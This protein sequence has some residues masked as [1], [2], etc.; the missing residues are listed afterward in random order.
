MSETCLIGLGAMGLGMARNILKAGVDLRGSDL[1]P[2][3]RARFTEAGGRAFD[4]AAEAAAGCDLLIL[5]VVNAAQARAALFDSGVV[6][7][8]GAGSTVMLCSTVAPDD[9]RALAADLEKAGHRLLDAPVSGGQ[10]GAEAGTLTLMTSGAEAAYDRAEPVLNAIAGTVHR[11]GDAPGLGA[12]Y[13]VVHQLAAGVHLVAAAEVMALG[14]RAGCDPEKLFEIV[15]T[16]AGQSWMFE[17]RVPRILAGETTPTSSV[18]IFVKDLGL[19][20]Q[21]GRDCATPLP[22]SAAAHQMMLAASAMGFGKL[23]DSCV[24]RAYEALTGYATKCTDGE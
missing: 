20:L 13:K 23:D 6:Q 5:M 4:S 1:S 10:V 12:T 3:A 2:Q 19:V 21:T 11:L 22:L 15:S 14:A 18:D 8:L 17:D 9:V 16:S 7:A 24:I